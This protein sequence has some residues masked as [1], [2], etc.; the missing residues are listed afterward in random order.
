MIKLDNVYILDSVEDILY[1]IREECIA[2]GKMYLNDI[3]P[4]SKYVQ[5]TC[6]F[7]A[8]GTER[9]PSC[10]VTRVSI[11]KGNK[12]VPA[13]L[14]HCFTCGEIFNLEQLVNHVFDRRLNDEFGKKWLMSHCTI[15]QSQEIPTLNLFH[16]EDMKYIDERE[17]KNYNRTHPYMY[18]RGLTNE[19]IKQFQ[20]GYDATFQLKKDGNYIPCLTFPIR[21]KDGNILFIARRSVR[22]KIFHYPTSVQKPVCYLYELYRDT[23]I[24]I[25]D[26]IIHILPELLI[27]ESLLNAITSWKYGLPAVALLGT[28]TPEQYKVIERLPVDKIYLG[29][30]PDE[31]GD[32]AVRR[33][34]KNVKRNNIY[35]FDIPEGKDINDLTEDE[36]LD[37]PILTP[38]EWRREFG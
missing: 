17:L 6:P 27:V 9:R 5:I 19:L 29:F 31:A 14:G 21:D 4:K 18:E 10:T 1:M 35:I 16:H 3:K 36:F 15:G 32:K 30:D 28:G 22:G 26:G 37:L 24:G 2:K 25:K 38:M 34:L 12:V 13:G 11:E 20:V 8:G 33:F 23:D 7:H